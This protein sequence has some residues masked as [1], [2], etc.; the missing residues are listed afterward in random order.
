MAPDKFGLF[1]YVKMPDAIRRETMAVCRER[2]DAA[3]LRGLSITYCSAACP[4]CVDE[5]T[6]RLAKMVDNQ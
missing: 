1:D 5:A 6:R 3:R 4:D 2:V